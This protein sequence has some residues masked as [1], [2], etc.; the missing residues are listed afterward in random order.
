MTIINIILIA[1][2]LLLAILALY[3]ALWGYH[4][5][6]HDNF[7]EEFEKQLDELDLINRRNQRR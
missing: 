2:A 4:T 5:K 1:S 7:N 6:Q 3:E